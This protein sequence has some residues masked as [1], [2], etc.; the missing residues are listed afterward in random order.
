MIQSVFITLDDGRRLQFSGPA[1][2]WPDDPPARIVDVKFGQPMPL[3]EGC[4][5][6]T[7]GGEANGKSE[8]QQ[9]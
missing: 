5:I 7:I 4:H 8:D 3:P 2:I 1:A 6:E 9:P